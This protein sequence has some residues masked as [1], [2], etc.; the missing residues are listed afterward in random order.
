[1]SLILRKG[2]EG[3]IV[4]AGGGDMTYTVVVLH[5]RDGRYSVVVPALSGCATWGETLPQALDMAKEAILAYLDG[6][7]ELGKPVP[8]DTE[9]VAVDLGDAT[10]ASVY[11][12]LAEE[13]AAV[14]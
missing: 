14:A 3:A 1:V 12:V 11:R 5:E 8:P 9:T 6:L 7:Q 4:A 2:R 10:E 13:A